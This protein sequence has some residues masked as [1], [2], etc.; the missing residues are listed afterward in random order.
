MSLIIA[1]PVRGIGL[2]APVSVGYAEAVRALSK[3]VDVIPASVT[4]STDVVRARNRLAATVLRDMPDV[5][6]VLWWDDDVYPEDVK[7]V[8][9]MLN[10]FEDVIAAPYVNKDPPVHWMHQGASSLDGRGLLEV[11]ETGFGFVLTSR[12]CLERMSKA[13]STIHDRAAPQPHLVANLFGMLYDK[14][15]EGLLLLSEDL[16]FCRRWRELGGKIWVDGR[17]G[18]VL[19]H[20]GRWAWSGREIT[21]GVR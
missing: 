18:N 15:P 3:T 13:S 1:T 21:G 14:S 9:R 5:S 8:E 11:T 7:I 2:D 12:A 6:H 19:R 17:P 20:V 4:F 10:A 16:S